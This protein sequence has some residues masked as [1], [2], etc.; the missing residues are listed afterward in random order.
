VAGG[1]DVSGIILAPAYFRLESD[2]DGDVGRVSGLTVS[3]YN[4]VKGEQHGVSLGLVNYAWEVNG[5]QL[6]LLN[7][8]ASNRKGLR[9][10][11]LFN[12]RWD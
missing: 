2:D 4:H 6:G 8:V 9:L 7:Y 3:A 10:L 1:H 11:P 12:K 5:V